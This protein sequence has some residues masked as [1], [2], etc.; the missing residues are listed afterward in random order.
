MTFTSIQLNHEAAKIQL[1]AAFSEAKNQ[2][3]LTSKYQDEIR[4]VINGEHL[5]YRYILITNLLAKAINQQV[6]ALALQVG[7]DFDNAFDSRSLCHKVFV[8]FERD[9]LKGRL[10]R[11]N[12][13]YLNKPA[14]HKALSL[15]NAVRKGKDRV[16]LELCIKVLSQCTQREAKKGLADAIYLTLHRPSINDSEILESTSTNTVLN[17][18]RFAQLLLKNSNEGESCALLVGLAFHFLSIGFDTAMEINVHPVNQSG[19]SSK[20]VSD[21][22][23]YFEQKLRFTAEVKDKIFTKEDVDH[24]AHKVKSA[25]HNAMFFIT[26]P[27]ASTALSLEQLGDIGISKGVS[28]S[29]IAISAFYETALGLCTEG[30][31]SAMVWQMIVGI[32]QNAKMKQATIV[33]VQNAA[34]LAQLI[35]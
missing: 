21:V 9:Q 24:A 1:K 33:D 27:N 13:P 4:E 32:C 15:D 6:N 18:Q 26:G 31:S 10:G 2:Q 20:E 29:M 14:R 25:G 17:L 12:E 30:I 7:A 3:K 16:L 11:S 35:E 8:P 34:R 28:I 5:T 22:D 23:V 19:A